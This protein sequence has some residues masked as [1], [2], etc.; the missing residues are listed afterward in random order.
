MHIS[1]RPNEKIYINGAVL[2]VDRKV[3][4]ELMN[5]AVFLLEAHVMLEEKATTPLRK[6]YFIVQLML[7]EPSDPDTKKIMFNLQSLSIAGHSTDMSIVAGVAAVTELVNKGRAFEAL[8]VIRSMLPIEDRLIDLAHGGAAAAVLPKPAPL[9]VGRRDRH[10]ATGR[11]RA[12][13]GPRGA[14]SRRVTF[15]Q[16]LLA[17]FG[18][19]G[20]PNG[21][22]LVFCCGGGYATRLMSSGTATRSLRKDSRCRRAA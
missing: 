20:L 16:R 1:L 19:G 11:A 12:S 5:D 4:I 17:L 2:K 18:A 3:S 8:K 7:M 13:R 6:L 14:Q 22:R 21:E 10:S 9:R 15:G